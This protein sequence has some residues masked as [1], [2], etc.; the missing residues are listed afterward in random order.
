MDENVPLAT[1]KRL[2][3]VAL[4]M[5]WN[6]RRTMAAARCPCRGALS[7]GEDRVQ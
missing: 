4:P 3:N 6:P 1:V 2:V 5:N 7:N